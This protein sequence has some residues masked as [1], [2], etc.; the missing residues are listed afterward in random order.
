MLVDVKITWAK[1]KEDRN[2]LALPILYLFVYGADA[3]FTP[4]LSLYYVHCGFSS[5][6]QAILLGSL[7][8]ALCLGNFLVSIFAKDAKTS[9]LLLKIVLIGEALASLL[10]SLAKPFWL[11]LI[12]LI[13]FAFTNSAFFNLNDSFA[14]IYAKRV[15]RP[16]S[17]YRLFGSLAYI[18]VTVITSF[19]IKEDSYQ[20][21]FFVGA[22]L[23]FLGFLSSFF[24]KPIEASIEVTEEKKSE[25]RKTSFPPRFFLLLIG[26]TLVFGT[27]STL[28]YVQPVYYERLN[29]A[30]SDYSLWYGIRVAVELVTLL[31]LPLLS[32]K[33]K[34]SYSWLV[35]L[36]FVL[37]F[38]SSL[39]T[40]LVP[41]VMTSLIAFSLIRGFGFGFY[42]G[43]FVCFINALVGDEGSSKLLTIV[44]SASYAWSGLS[45]LLSPY[46]YDTIGFFYTF[47]I[48]VILIGVGLL[49]F[50][51]FCC[52]S[53]KRENTPNEK[54]A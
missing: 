16:F 53:K 31:L 4:F 48:M 14:A 32:K 37:L 39:I 43:S 6:E 8:F 46:L 3:L 45:C 36:S 30:N 10:F 13:L 17:H 20:V 49:L 21:L 38:L 26:Y 42:L 40:W 1:I 2:S 7:P 50:V 33:K 12:A 28:Q 24:L 25:G 35:S 47:L 52:F 27:F 23:F 9:F 15:H 18:I 54:G 29:L 34:L 41:D 44:S 22:S 51:F 19:F 5:L 11:L